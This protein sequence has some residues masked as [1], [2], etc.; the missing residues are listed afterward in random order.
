MQGQVFHSSEAFELEL[1]GRIQELTIRYHTYGKLNQAK[2]N[3]IWV[4][5]AL[6]ASSS[7]KDWWP[8]LFGEGNVFDSNKYF[9][10]C[11]NNLG[12]PY[13][14]SSPLH[15]DPQS[16][17]RYGMS[18]PDFTLKDTAK[19]IL[20]LMSA[21]EIEQIHMLIGGSCGGNIALEIAIQ[22]GNK[23]KNLVIMCCSSKETPWTIA[24]HE[25]QRLALKADPE[26]RSNHS[27]AAKNGLKAARAFAL[28]FYRSSQSMNFRQIEEEEDKTS[29]FKAASYVAYQGDKFVNRFDAHCYFKLLN[30]LDT[31]NVGRNEESVLKALRKVKAKTLVFGIDTDIFIPVAEQLYLVKHIENAKYAE[32]K[33][34][35]GHDAFLIETDQIRNHILA[36]RNV[37]K[38]QTKV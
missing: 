6:T 29:G 8:E 35:F 17:E 1:G 25:S 22:A 12:S 15:I 19:A 27:G 33:S 31:H 18:F 9:I 26:F 24:I 7:V 5:H 2:D 32:I 13:G 11:A 16:N 10:V 28:P 34:I 23:I 3:V 30:A 14:S 4:C 37:K 38:E 20:K 21:L 36:Q